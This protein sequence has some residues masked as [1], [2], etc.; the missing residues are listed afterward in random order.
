[1]LHNITHRQFIGAVAIRKNGSTEND[2]PE[3]YVRV[4]SSDN[5][6]HCCLRVHDEGIRGSEDTA[7]YTDRF[8]PEAS[9]PATHWTGSWVGPTAVCVE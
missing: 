8:N 7:T 5:V 3:L 4:S 2:C 6:Q 9:A 1:M